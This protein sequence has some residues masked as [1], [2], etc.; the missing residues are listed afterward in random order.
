MRV[1]SYE[2]FLQSIE[3]SYD[4]WD[5]FGYKNTA[6]LSIDDEGILFNI[7]PN[8]YEIYNQIKLGDVKTKI[9]FV[10]GSRKYY[11]LINSKLRTQEDRNRW[12]ELTNDLAYNID[13]LDYFLN[14]NGEEKPEVKE[15]IKK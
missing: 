1:Y 10:L 11:E 14:K 12:Y 2:E 7:Y 4:N 5:D 13:L 8:K 15:E 6:K 3:I 9:L